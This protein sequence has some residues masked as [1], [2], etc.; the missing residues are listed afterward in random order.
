[1]GCWRK[2]QKPSMPYSYLSY[3]TTEIPTFLLT[4]TFV[5]EMVKN[6]I[7]IQQENAR[8]SSLSS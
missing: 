1:M 3:I 6:T 7:S 4:F 2:H 5:V 8:I